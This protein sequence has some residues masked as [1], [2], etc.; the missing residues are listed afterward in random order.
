MCVRALLYA[1]S[2]SIRVGFEG[3]KLKIVDQKAYDGRVSQIGFPFL[4]W[5][6]SRTLGAGH[7]ASPLAFRR[8]ASAL[9]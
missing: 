4:R 3:S 7:R 6:Y 5:L 8:E 2:H 1:V 9:Q